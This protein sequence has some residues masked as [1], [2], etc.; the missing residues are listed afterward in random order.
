[1][2]D[3]KEDTSAVNFEA[4]SSFI[5]KNSSMIELQGEDQLV[6]KIMKPTLQKMSY[7]N[8]MNFGMVKAEASSPVKINRNNI[9]Q[10][11]LKLNS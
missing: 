10:G 1:M 6:S 9:L 4:S 2:N 3:K 11:N 8:S 5:G 7:R